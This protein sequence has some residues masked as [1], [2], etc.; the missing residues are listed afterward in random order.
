MSDFKPSYRN[1]VLGVLA[2]GYLLNSFDRS[3]LGILL[4]PIKL[5]F[6]VSDTALGLLGGIAFAAFYSTFGIPIALWADRSNR[7]NIL[8]LSI[9]VW[10]AMTA[11]CGL[12]ATFVMLLLARVGTAI[13][14]AGGSP[15]SHALISDYFSVQ[16]RGT[17]LAI[18]AL[19]APAGAMLGGL[20]GGISNE[21]FGWRLT[22]ILAG[23]PGLLLAPLVLFTITE[24]R[25]V[26]AVGT[27]PLP[28][29]PAPPLQEIVR[30]LW[31]RRSFRHL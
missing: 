11:M 19:G 29:T 25:S 18:Y 1:Y 10:S 8:A 5:E 28:R 26:A 15:P 16:R 9:F 17:A 14:E 13:G 6:G 22:F 4:E 3:I 30:Y 24:P 23:L 7:R 2:F 20:L 31:Q 12:S 21:L 27:R